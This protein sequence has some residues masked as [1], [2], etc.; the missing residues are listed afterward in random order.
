MIESAFEVT[1]SCDEETDLEEKEGVSEEGLGI[2]VKV[3][4]TVKV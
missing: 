2:V 3:E 4:G 1:F